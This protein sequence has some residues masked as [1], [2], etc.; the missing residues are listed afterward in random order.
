M[1]RV[2]VA[3]T[4]TLVLLATLPYLNGLHNE[5]VYDDHAQIVRNDLVQSLDPRPVLARGS[6]TQGRVHFYRPVTIYSFAVNYAAAGLRPFTYHLT[7]LSLHVANTWL[8][9]AI[10]RELLG[11]NLA[12]FIAAALFAVH[13][14]HTEAVTPIFGRADLLAALS[15]LFGLW[16][17]LNNRAGEASDRSDR[18]EV[19]VS[20]RGDPAGI[21]VRRRL[22]IA[23]VFIAGMLAK[24]SAIVL[25]PAIVVL[26]LMRRGKRPVRA[27]LTDRWPLYAALL[28]ACVAYVVLRVAALGAFSEANT[29]TRYIENPLIEVTP[30]VRIATALWVGLRY[31]RLFVWPW[32]LSADYSY[33]QIP[34]IRQWTDPRLAVIVAVLLLG[35][36]VAAQSQWRRLIQ[37]DR[38]RHAQV[39]SERVDF[40]SVW[41]ALLFLVL[42]APVS[43]VFFPLGT[44]MAERLLY[45]PSAALCLLFGTALARFAGDGPRWRTML[46]TAIATIAL[47]A[48]L[49]AAAA[50]N[51]EWRSDEQ[52]FAATART[53]PRSAK[54]HFNYGE[55]QLE[56][57]RAADAEAELRWAVA[58]AP[59][60]PEAHNVLGTIYLSGGDLSMA[61]RE[62]RAAVRDAPAYAPAL[63]NLGIVLRRQD[64]PLEAE[65]I[66]QKAVALDPTMAAA[67]ANLGLLAEQRG[68]P[69]GAVAHYRRAYALDATLEVLR[70][71]ADALAAGGGP[72]ERK[73]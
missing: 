13:A 6:V 50:R 23:V 32:P 64:Q 37:T 60:Y 34:L 36:L 12:A 41:L 40:S 63:A 47:G 48:N 29:S 73:R 20:R 3:R 16:L 51:R 38:S 10:G 28:G 31:I 33:S 19:D 2:A 61:E 72:A 49:W 62:F 9:L 46:A 42:I 17:A 4:L 55:I 65:Q 54:A 70:A 52:L 7:N 57:G 1:G 5:F 71:R 11:V 22:A 66:L 53:S 35:V 39:V 56:H 24:E 43:N 18:A 67:Y 44:I 59:V 58:I 68:D 21:S 26:D 25:P 27:I 45:L 8:L 15:V 69:G 30:F 14:L